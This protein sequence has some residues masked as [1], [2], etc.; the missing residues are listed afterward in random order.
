MKIQSMILALALFAGLFAGCVSKPAPRRVYKEAQFE[1]R[2][3]YLRFCQTHE[4]R[5]GRCE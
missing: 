5:T 3:E 2:L 4:M 1:S